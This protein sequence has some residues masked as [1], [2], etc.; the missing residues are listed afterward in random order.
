MHNEPTITSSPPLLLATAD[1][2]T[3]TLDK[4][5]LRKR[6]DITAI[7]ATISQV[8]TPDELERAT[9][10]LG[11]V[12]KFLKAAEDDANTIKR[13]RK[14]WMDN[15][16]DFMADFI[17]P[18]EKEKQRLTGLINHY[19]RVKLEEADART[20]EEAREK[21]DNL[22]RQ[23]EAQQEQRK[24]M[25]ELTKAKTAKARQDLEAKLIEMQMKAEDIA[26]DLQAEPSKAI[27][28]AKPGNL[29]VR[30]RLDFKITNPHAFIESYPE[31][32]KWNEE[33][34]TFKLDRRKFLEELN[35]PA[36][37]TFQWLKFP[38][39]QPIDGIPKP[40][41][42]NVFKDVSSFTR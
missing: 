11:L 37:N 26:L 16:R 41:G 8:T 10:G 40:C 22:K 3:V 24:L 27:E 34:E 29:T 42:C 18:A 36:P 9:K 2:G 1:L 23:E 28:I 33:T 13:P 25:D 7:T 12:S 21:A 39:E 30:V 5:A 32:W 19:Q 6:N 15:L 17:S 31:F 4:S 14:A 35:K 38:E 20:R